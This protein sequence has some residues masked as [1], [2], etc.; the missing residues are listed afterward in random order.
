MATAAI[1]LGR[2][3]PFLLHAYAHFDEFRIERQGTWA[4]AAAIDPTA[5]ERLVADPATADLLVESKKE[6]L[7]NRV[8]ATPAFFINGRRYV[9]DIDLEEMVDV[10]LEEAERAAGL[11]FVAGPAT[12]PGGAP[13]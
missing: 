2:P 3:W 8:D 6:G 7:R 12:D 1:L 9:G 4:E 11:T 5:F 13:P 10:L